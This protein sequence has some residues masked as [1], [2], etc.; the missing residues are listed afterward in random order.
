MDVM[1]SDLTDLKDRLPLMESTGKNFYK[2]FPLS[3]PNKHQKF[4]PISL[5][6]GHGFGIYFGKQSGFE[7]NMGVFREYG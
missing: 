7:D 3:E 1:A 6:Q 4:P 5:S 2:S